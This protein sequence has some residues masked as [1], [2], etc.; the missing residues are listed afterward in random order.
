MLLTLPTNELRGTKIVEACL[1]KLNIAVP[2]IPALSA[3]LA[4]FVTSISI[5]KFKEAS[6]L[7]AINVT[8]PLKVSV[9]NTEDFM[10]ILSPDFR[11]AT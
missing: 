11:F 3:F 8:T 1:G 6:A 2:Y 5:G 10:V 4:L 7:G 9:G